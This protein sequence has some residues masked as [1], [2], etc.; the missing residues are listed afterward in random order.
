MKIHYFVRPENGVSFHRFVQPMDYIHWDEGTESILKWHGEDET[1]EGLDCDILAYSLF[2]ET[3]AVL[4]KN[5]QSKGTR[6]VVD[7]DDDWDI[8]VSH[9]RYQMLTE[10]RFQQRVLDNIRIADVVTCPTLRLQEKVRQYNKNTVVIPNALPYGYEHYHDKDRIASD[11]TRFIYVGGSTHY[12]DIRMLE[13]KFKRIGSDPHI[14]NNSNFI[15]AGYRPHYAKRYL[16][17]YDQ[18]QQNNNWAPYK[19]PGVWD[20]MA[21]IFAQTQVEKILPTLPPQDYITHYDHGDVAIVPLKESTWASYKSPLKLAEAATRNIPVICSQVGPYSDVESVSGVIWAPTTADWIPAIRKC[22]KDKEY[23]KDM[24]LQL[25]EYCR[26]HYDLV[27][28]NE[29]RKQV[30]KSLM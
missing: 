30:Y 10:N 22:I 14:K 12:E 1:E 17:N 27:R 6:I 18:E 16:T 26:E 5:L 24:G 15:M 8:P 21:S 9:P 3:D 23:V 19:V 20:K 13:G 29:T 4:L 28:W 25:G 2:L 7:V 11:K